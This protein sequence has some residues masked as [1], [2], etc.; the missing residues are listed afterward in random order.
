MP[1]K[2]LGPNLT[3]REEQLLQ[4]QPNTCC[5]S[6]RPRRRRRVS[7]LQL[8]LVDLSLHIQNDG[9]PEYCSVE[10]LSLNRRKVKTLLYSV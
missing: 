3:A 6:G 10:V 5:W 7:L 8:D 2:V 1:G 9:G 4:K